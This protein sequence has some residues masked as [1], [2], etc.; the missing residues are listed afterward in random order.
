MEHAVIQLINQMLDAFNE[1]KYTLGTFIDLSKIFNTVDHNIL[2]KNLDMYGIK[3]KNWK[4]FHSYLTNR[5]QFI[6]C[7]GQ[8]NDLEVLWCGVPQG[9]IIGP[10]LFLKFVNDLKNSTNLLDDDTNFVFLLTKT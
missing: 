5:K 8:D 7:R 3:G 10:L 2:L 9:S 1:N 4:W 6:K